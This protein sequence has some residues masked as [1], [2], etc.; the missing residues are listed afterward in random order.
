LLAND[1]GPSFRIAKLYRRTSKAGATYFS[2]R[3]GFAK[4]AL[5]KSKETAEDGGEI[6]SLMVSEAPQRS[7]ERSVEAPAGVRHPATHISV[8]CQTTRFP[9]CQNG[10]DV[11]G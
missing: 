10:V 1:Y 3:L 4:I 11:S 6:W 8:G 7:E 5:L 9:L 2:G